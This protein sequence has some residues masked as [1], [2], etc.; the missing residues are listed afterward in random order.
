[1]SFVAIP[2]ATNDTASPDVPMS[3]V[4]NPDV[5]VSFVAHPDAATEI[6]VTPKIDAITAYPTNRIEW[7]RGEPL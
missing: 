1:M 6:V 7:V 3:F 4:A 2:D 5:P